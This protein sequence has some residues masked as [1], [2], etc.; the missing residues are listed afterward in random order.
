MRLV[1]AYVLQPQN[2][3][4]VGLLELLVGSEQFL[5]EEAGSLKSIV[6]DEIID[7][8][9]VQVKEGVLGGHEIVELL[10]EE[11]PLVIVDEGC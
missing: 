3:F 6:L 10:E 9:L 4:L 7:D 11:V 2:S 5:D 1:I 8:H